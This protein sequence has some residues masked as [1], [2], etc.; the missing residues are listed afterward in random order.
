MQEGDIV[1]RE[2]PDIL[3]AAASNQ[4][5]HHGDPVSRVAEMKRDKGTD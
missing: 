5:I 2:N 1:A 3:F 4:V